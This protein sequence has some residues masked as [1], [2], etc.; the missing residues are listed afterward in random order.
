[1]LV[2]QRSSCSVLESDSLEGMQCNCDRSRFSGCG[3]MARVGADIC[4]SFSRSRVGGGRSVRGL[5]QGLG[6]LLVWD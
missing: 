3:K 4:I 2:N 6:D 5:A 1:M